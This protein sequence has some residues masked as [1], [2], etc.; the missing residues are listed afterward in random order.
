MLPLSFDSAIGKFKD[1]EK[2]LR[3]IRRLSGEIDL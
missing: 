3:S 1:L 2:L